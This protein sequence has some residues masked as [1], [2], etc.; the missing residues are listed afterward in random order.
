MKVVVTEILDTWSRE[1]FGTPYVIQKV[2][3]KT[4]YGVLT[5]EFR[6]QELVPNQM[7]DYCHKSVVERFTGRLRKIGITIELVGNYP[8]IYLDRVNDIKV[9]ER[10]GGKHG[11]TAFYLSMKPSSDASFSDRR[12]VF[13]KIRDV[14]KNGE[15]CGMTREK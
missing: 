3:L 12:V 4:V 9:L 7:L 11:F 2:K 5:K 8:W 15:C 10:F 14:I 1:A 13:K 6:N